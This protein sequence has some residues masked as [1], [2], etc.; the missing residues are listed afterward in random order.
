MPFL[1]GSLLQHKGRSSS[2]CYHCTVSMPFLTGSLLQ[3]LKRGNFKISKVS[4]YALFNGQSVATSGKLQIIGVIGLYVSMPFLTGSLLQQIFERMKDMK[5]RSFYA[6]FNGQSVA[7]NCKRIGRFNWSGF[8]ALFNG[9]SVATDVFC[10][11]KPFTK[12]SMPFLTGSLLQ[13]EDR[14]TGWK[15]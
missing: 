9:Q 2:G 1:T 15:V 12:V 4:F 11:S 6:L 3:L 7:T 10:N 13:R 8:Y 14:R 5:K